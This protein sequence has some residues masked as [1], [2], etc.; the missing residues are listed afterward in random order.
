MK[1]K[2]ARKASNS[3]RDN[4]EQGLLGVK[5]MASPS[6]VWLSPRGTCSMATLRP[7]RVIS[8]MALRHE[9]TRLTSTRFTSA[10]PPFK[11]RTMRLESPRIA[12]SSE[13]NL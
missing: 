9:A 1:L 4:L 5:P 12:P 6:A 2:V 13:W 10:A 7:V 11:A 8:S 3:G